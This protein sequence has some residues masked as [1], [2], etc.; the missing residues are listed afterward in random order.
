VT[1]P[2]PDSCLRH[3]GRRG[4]RHGC[5]GADDPHRLDVAAALARGVRDAEGMVR[6]ATKQKRPRGQVQH[7][8][9]QR[10]GAAGTLNTVRN[11]LADISFTV[12]TYTPGRFGITQIAEP[13]FLGKSAAATSVAFQPVDAKTL[14]IVKAHRGVLDGKLLP[15][16][17]IETFKLD[18]VVRY[19]TTF[20]G[21]LCNS[22]LAFILCQ[23]SCDRLPPEG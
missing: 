9:A 4:Q 21:G 14:A 16:E 3:A 2:G 13:P 6:A 22:S 18:K 5:L 11:G 12:H 8:A 15:A 7:P 23:P 10:C 1:P 20:A 19:A 17:P